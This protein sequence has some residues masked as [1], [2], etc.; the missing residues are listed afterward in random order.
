MGQQKF[1]LV[2]L[3]AGLGIFVLLIVRTG[4]GTIAARIWEFGAGFLLLILIS[5]V[6]HILRTIAWYHSIEPGERQVRFRDLFGIRMVGEA[7]TDLTFLGPLLGET[8][9]GLTLSQRISPEHSASS[10]VIENLAYAFASG[11]VIVSGLAL[12]VSAF[13]MPPSVETAGLGVLIVLFLFGVTVGLIVK[14]R[15]RIVGKVLDG[16]KKLKIDWGSYLQAR[17]DKVDRFEGNIHDFYRCHPVESIFILLLE[18]LAIFTGV[19]EAYIILHLTVHRSSFLAA[20]II[21]AVN[22]VVNLFF[23]FVPLRMGVDEG[24]AALVVKAVGYGAAEGVSLA[25]IR[26]IRMLFWVAVGLLLAAR[27]SVALRRPSE[28]GTSPVAA[29][30]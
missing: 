27:Y 21:E 20:F 8:V 22:R 30:K 3:L 18:I 19:I 26:K 14:K 24:G 12:F 9:K 15:Y 13:A 2:A 4:P 6:R 23:A 5:G 7:V 11:L 10:V 28:D 29:S 16:L 17:R 25:V 1:R